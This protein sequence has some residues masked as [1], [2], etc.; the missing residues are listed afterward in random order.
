MARAESCPTS[1]SASRCQ[2]AISVGL[3]SVGWPAL[4]IAAASDAALET[5]DIASMTTA[6]AA[7]ALRDVAVV[8]GKADQLEAAI[9][10][11]SKWFVLNSP[12]NPTGVVYS[13]QWKPGISAAKSRKN[14]CI[15]KP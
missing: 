2:P 10:P 8:K 12:S 6:Q 9:T 11:K 15:M 13:E 3:L 4:T 7:R 14:R 5:A 1:G